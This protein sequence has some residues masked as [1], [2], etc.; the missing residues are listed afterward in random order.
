[1][2][3]FSVCGVY[4]GCT[5]V[6]LFSSF[7]Y[8]FLRGVAFSIYGAL[9]W[10]PYGVYSVSRFLLGIG[11]GR[12]WR[13]S[14]FVAFMRHAGW[15]VY[16]IYLFIYLF[17]VWR[18]VAFRVAFMGHWGGTLVAFTAFAAFIRRLGWSFYV[19]FECL[20]QLGG[21]GAGPLWRLQC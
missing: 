4:E 2:A 11:V 9:G 5:L 13:F 6:F 14:A 12:L 3:L 10:D 18:G 16:F 8:L 7:I 15:S 21:F 19:H 20:Q 17:I 1:M